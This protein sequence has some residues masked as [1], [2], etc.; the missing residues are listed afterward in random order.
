[1]AIR[2]EEGMKWADEW[3]PRFL[4]DAAKVKTQ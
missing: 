2:K 1:M 3:H 4:P